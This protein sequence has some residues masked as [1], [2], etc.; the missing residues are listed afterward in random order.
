MQS[1]A[2]LVL[3]TAFIFASASAADAQ[4]SNVTMLPSRFSFGGD[5]A[6]SQPKGEF[7]N[8]VPNGYGFDLTGMFRLDPQG[9]FNLRAD[10]GGV[11]YGHERVRVG[12]PASG[13]VAVD[14]N[15]DNQIGFGAFG[16]QLQIPD[17]WFRPYANAAVAA[18]YF[19]TESSISGADNSESFLQTTN[20]DDWSHAWVFGGGVMI[21]FGRSIGALNLGARYH[22]GAS[23]TYLK[24]G[25]ITDNPNGSIN[26]NP[27]N[28][29]TDLV[30]WQLGVSFAIPRS[31]GH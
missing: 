20:L 31:T 30:L 2:V 28:S 16:V 9:Y 13:R 22:Y 23:A 18:T 4:F 15:T 17:G 7:A 14:L 29:K 5:L 26:L 19:W 10:L 25:D 27:R 8:N 3:S 11:R 24:E 1:K 6:L 12:F 21:P